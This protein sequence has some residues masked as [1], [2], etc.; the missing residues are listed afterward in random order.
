MNLNQFSE[1]MLNCLYLSYWAYVTSSKKIL[2]RKRT[3][4]VQSCENLIQIQKWMHVL[5][6]AT[7][8]SKVFRA[9]KLVLHNLLFTKNRVHYVVFE[10]KSSSFILL[11]GKKKKRVRS[12]LF[13]LR[14]KGSIE[15]EK[16]ERNQSKFKATLHKMELRDVLGVEKK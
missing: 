3:F 8:P 16:K 2:Q 6:L 4:N 15:S 10:K 11:Y 13:F 9:N 12:I 5:K 14:T 1:I 7:K